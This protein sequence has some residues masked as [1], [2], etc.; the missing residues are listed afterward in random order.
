ML[1]TLSMGKISLQFF[2][3]Q[4]LIQIT[5]HTLSMAKI[6]LHTLSTSSSGPPL[7]FGL[8]QVLAK[9]SI[10]SLSTF[11]QFLALHSLF[12]YFNHWS[13]YPSIIFQWAFRAKWCRTNANV[14]SLRRIDVNTASF[15]HHV[16]AGLFAYFKLWPKHFSI[17][18]KHI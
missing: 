13:K 2:L 11:H 17:I 6:S 5:L 9:I 14:T 8:F 10:H 16:P 12:C 18:S 4:A 1:H 7:S 15:L 3:F